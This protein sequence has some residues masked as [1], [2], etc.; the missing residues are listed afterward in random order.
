M[1][2]KSQCLPEVL[3]KWVTV[4]GFRRPL[5]SFCRAIKNSTMIDFNPAWIYYLGDSLARLETAQEKVLLSHIV[6]NI[7]AAKTSLVAFLEHQQHTIFPETRDRVKDVLVWVNVILPDEPFRDRLL[8]STEVIELIS[9]INKAVVTFEA[10]ATRVYLVGLERQRALDPSTLIED[11]GS[12][13]SPDCWQHLSN[14]TQREMKECGR[15]LAFE[16]FTASGFHALRAVEHETKDYACLLLRAAPEKRDLGHYIQI[17][18]ENGANA[19]LLSSLDDIR[20]L[21]RNPLMHP[22]DWLSKDD[23]ISIFNTSQTVLERLIADM[24]L[25]RLLPPK[26]P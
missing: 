9:A 8:N 2:A 25:R 23:A 4:A 18:K 13:V 6:P 16:R 7:S 15:C 17:L 14:V 3:A 20:R 11:I 5:G 1:C 19:K 22:D 10:E 24:E 26:S 12:A 21:D